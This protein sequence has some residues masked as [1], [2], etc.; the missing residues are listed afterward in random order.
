MAKAKKQSIADIEKKVQKATADV[1]KAVLG[2]PGFSEQAKKNITGLLDKEYR[3]LPNLTAKQK[4]LAGEALVSF[5]TI[6]RIMN[7]DVGASLDN[8]EAIADVFDVSVYQILLPSL[9]IGN[10]QVVKGAT[11]E[12]KRAYRLWKRDRTSPKPERREPV[13]TEGPVSETF[14]GKPGRSRSS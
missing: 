7:E 13:T 14:Y 5:S 11:E 1:K 9:D 12:E 2:A 4:K 6:Q 3:D 8:I 10:P